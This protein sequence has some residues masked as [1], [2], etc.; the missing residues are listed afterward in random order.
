MTNERE[1]KKKIPKRVLI[2]DE[3]IQVFVIKRI[4]EL[5][6]REKPTTGLIR[7]FSAEFGVTRSAARE[8]IYAAKSGENLKM[9]HYN[10][11]SAHFSYQS[12]QFL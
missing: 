3:K 4:D 7:T 11:F 5:L 10:Y 2:D 9:P 8:I 1:I 6:R 12:L